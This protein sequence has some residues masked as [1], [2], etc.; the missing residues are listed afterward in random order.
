[1]VTRVK[2]IMRM[3]KKKNT[4]PEEVMVNLPLGSVRWLVNPAC[5]MLGSWI[6]HKF[7]TQGEQRGLSS[8]WLRVFNRIFLSS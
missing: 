1:M 5:R 2:T 4:E 3:V 7:C 6:F 8:L